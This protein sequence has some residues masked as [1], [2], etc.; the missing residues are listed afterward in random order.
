MSRIQNNKVNKQVRP[1]EDTQIT[2]MVAGYLAYWPVFLAF[3]LVAFTGAY[4]YVRYATVKYEAN[5]TLLIKD[6][7][8]GEGYTKGVEEVNEISTTKIIENEI[9]VLQGRSIMDS[10]VK[11][12]RFY[13]PISQEGKIKSEPGYVSSPVLV[14]APNPDSVQAADKVYM[15]YNASNKTVILDN[16]FSCKLNEW[17]KTPYGVLRFV[18][19]PRY[20][21]SY[22]TKPFYFGLRK[23]KFV[24]DQMLG[25]LKVETTGKL[26][27]VLNLSYRSDLPEK[28]ED[29]LNAIIYY[30]NEGSV[31]EKNVL[32]RNTIAS[33][34]R[35]LVSVKADLD[36]IE[37]N[38][39]LYKARS[40]A[41]D[42]STQSNL[43][44]EGISTT[45]QKMGEV[46]VQLSALDQLENYVASS[47]SNEVLAPSHLGIE[48]Q[49]LTSL[50]ENLNRS[51]MEYDRLKR[52][53][54]ENNPML[55]S[56]REQITKLKPNILTNIRNQRKVLE[57]SR[58]NLSSTTN[59]LGSM[60]NVIPQKEKELV[61]ISRDEDIK[62]GI[63]SFLLKKREESELSY[64]NALS[65]SK[66]VS[67][68]LSNR[69]P[70]SPKK[71]L[72]YLV[73][74]F[75][76]LLVPV[77][78]ITG[79]EMFNSKILYRKEIEELTEIP[80]IGEIAHNKSDK[81]LV[82]EPGKRSFIAEEFRKIRVS[83]LF[84]GID[85][86]H[87][88]ILVTSSLPEEGKSF[89]AANLALSLAMTGKKVALVDMDLHNPSLSSTFGLEEHAGVS[90]YLIGEKKIEDIIYDVPANE[91]L[92]FI[93]S[94]NLQP[95]ASEL[96][97]NGK[98]QQ[99]IS[100]LEG[101]Y[102][103]VIIDTAPVVLITDAY[104]LSACCDATLYV[105]R[106]KYTPKMVVKRIDENNKVNPLKNPAIIF[107]GVKTRGFFKNNYGYGYD[108][109]YGKKIKNKEG[110]K[111]SAYQ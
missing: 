78:A 58:N 17:T 27:S 103:L 24:T 28:A 10:V 106:H 9:E 105:V 91:N 13:A 90:D 59:R 34:D 1:G 96:L 41:T 100:Y 14:E 94:G 57:L 69:L 48:D 104:M 20:R 97:E 46:N 2:Q 86:Y 63:Y 16:N 62:R 26:A 81:Q 70:V 82:V 18:P 83:L 73:A 35:R 80:V 74:G 29:I 55:A 12:L 4:F 5:A 15:K 79:K 33:I 22:N 102:D 64:A 44:L 32:I 23:T 43:Y 89:V 31:A 72:I 6:G 107:N 50:V 54:A 3:L 65:D 99:L 61:E 7:K 53:V 95:D 11:R 36:S 68:A 110:K 111:V 30:Y 101:V 19:N 77:L 60:L 67:N 93:S 87:K 25:A 56:L 42:L 98:V 66:T 45:G 38:V 40:N 21:A 75:L 108:Y 85:A 39:Q 49:S 51:Q 47:N 76:G 37:R 92:S 109:V 8:K 71:M 52:T 88:K 84:L